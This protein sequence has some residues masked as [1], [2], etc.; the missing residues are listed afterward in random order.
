MADPAP[1]PS[2]RIL[3]RL[4]QR[5]ESSFQGESGAASSGAGD[6]GWTRHT[7]AELLALQEIHEAVGSSLDAARIL[8]VVVKRVA[9]L[10][11]A[12]RCSILLAARESAEASVVASHEDGPAPT[13]LDLGKYPEIRKALA[14]GKPVVVEDLH[15]DPLLAGVR[16]HLKALP[17]A[18][19]VVL[20]VRADDL[21]IGALFVRT[22]EAGRGFADREI[23]L[24]E[25]VSA[26]AGQALERSIRH[27]AVSDHARRAALEREVVLA[28][29]E[30]LQDYTELLEHTSDAIFGVDGT[31]IITGANRRATALTGYVHAELI[32]MPVARIVPPGEIRRILALRGQKEA[33]DREQYHLPI[34][35]AEGRRLGVPNADKPDSQELCF[36]PD[37]DV[38][39][40]I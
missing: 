39:G 9:E 5:L 35:N 32:G 1:P 31:G 20:P 23:R 38:G 22:R 7:K 16:A 30:L 3:P 10:L 19:I 21:V 15:H 4:I 36:V 40:F 13:S 18:S 12:A 24:L 28:R 27:E 6:P 8:G 37:G 25:A 26:L 11:G 17:G 29:Y 34:E 2:R 33:R 14:E